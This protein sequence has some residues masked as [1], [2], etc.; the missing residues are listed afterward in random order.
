MFLLPRNHFWLS[1]LANK[2]F[3]LFQVS[4]SGGYFQAESRV[5]RNVTR[6]KSTK[7]NKI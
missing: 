7:K 4:Q 2:L 6:L 5:E 1:V 3:A